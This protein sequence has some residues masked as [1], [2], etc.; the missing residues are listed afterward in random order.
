MW[1]NGRNLSE[2]QW[3]AAREQGYSDDEV[4]AMSWYVTASGHVSRRHKPR[5]GLDDQDVNLILT[6]LSYLARCPHLDLMTSA[7]RDDV[8]RTIERV[9]NELFGHGDESGQGRVD[10]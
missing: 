2:E 3:H 8:E 6:G 4:A 5:I 9:S 7:T 1:V 10:D